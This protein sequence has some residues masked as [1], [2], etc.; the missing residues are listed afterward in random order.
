MK[1]PEIFKS[2]KLNEDAKKIF[3]HYLY[4]FDLYKDLI[5]ESKF[6]G[7]RD[8]IISHIT[9]KTEESPS[10][11]INKAEAVEILS[12]LGTVN[13]LLT[14]FN[15][16]KIVRF[17]FLGSF[18]GYRQLVTRLGIITLVGVVG[19]A[20][21]F[22]TKFLV[23]KL[24][25]PAGNAAIVGQETDRSKWTI[26]KGH[27]AQ[28]IEIIVPAKFM[29]NVFVYHGQNLK[30]NEIFVQ[31]SGNE[32]YVLRTNQVPSS[33][34]YGKMIAEIVALNE[35]A[36]TPKPTEDFMA[37]TD[38]VPV[39]SDMPT[40]T[41]EVVLD[42][43]DTSFWTTGHQEVLI[44]VP[45]QLNFIGDVKVY[46]QYNANGPKVTL[47]D[48]AFEKGITPTAKVKRNEYDSN[49]TFGYYEAVKN[50]TTIG[51]NLIYL[52]EYHPTPV[53]R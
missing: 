39:Y 7:L 29:R 14:E 43:I 42:D 19:V 46:G 47:T 34:P 4:E 33:N 50:A 41:E 16:P 2:P 49:T 1:T 20:A 37:P 8:D 48:V 45:E 52:G 9:E 5:A 24:L 35:T 51:V 6:S 26:T 15:V 28:E 10:K 44:F 31:F 22:G 21:F 3:V 11:V 12:S 53:A 17:P 30:D 40:P 13:E 25:T 36:I 23:T 38:T 32:G 18:V 27:R